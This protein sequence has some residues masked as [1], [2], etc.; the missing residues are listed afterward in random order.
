M[1]TVG[2]E[3]DISLLEKENPANINDISRVC[4]LGKFLGPVKRPLGP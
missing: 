2:I 1:A 3:E 4:L